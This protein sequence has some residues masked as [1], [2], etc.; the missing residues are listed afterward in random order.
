MNITVILKY[1]Y[2]SKNLKF[3]KQTFSQCN[4]DKIKVCREL[5]ENRNK[6]FKNNIGR[7]SDS[8][9]YAIE[10]GGENQPHYFHTISSRTTKISLKLVMKANSIPLDYF[11]NY[12]Y[13]GP[14]AT[15]K[16][17]LQIMSYICCKRKD[18]LVLLLKNTGILLMYFL[19]NLHVGNPQIISK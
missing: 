16:V 9:N 15:L 10:K 6:Q 13:P 5:W 18:W 4:N 8:T 1:K 14:S 12:S 3:R 19:Y 17:L 11:I 2:F 7:L